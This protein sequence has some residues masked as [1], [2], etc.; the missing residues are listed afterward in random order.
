[1]DCY[2]SY[3]EIYCLHLQGRRVNL[4]WKSGSDTGRKGII[5]YA[6]YTLIIGGGGRVSSETLVMIYQTIWRHII[7]IV[8][9][10]RT[11]NLVRIKKA[12]PNYE[13]VFAKWFTRSSTYL[14]SYLPFT[15]DENSVAGKKKCY[16]HIL[17]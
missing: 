15:A 4:S 9:S 13:V 8:T 10:V 11:S 5:F 12:H 16:L 3:G 2:H 7:F 6:F 17:K 14:Y 1:V